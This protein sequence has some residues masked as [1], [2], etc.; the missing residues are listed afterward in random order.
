MGGQ[1]DWA[2]LVAAHGMIGVTYNPVYA[3]NDLAILLETLVLQS[4]ELGIDAG[5][6]GLVSS[7]GNCSSGLREFRVKESEIYNGLNTGVFLYGTVPWT[8]DIRSGTSMLLVKTGTGLTDEIIKSMDEFVQKAP[9]AG[10]KTE[11]INY[12]E[13]NK[14]FDTTEQPCAPWEYGINKKYTSDCDMMKNILGFLQQELL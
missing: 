2:A 5:H 9:E 4:K 8:D 10:I 7:C 12:K 6:L 1:I 13:G 14:Y 11:L 3:E